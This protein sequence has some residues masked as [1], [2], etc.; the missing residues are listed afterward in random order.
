MQRELRLEAIKALS[1][2]GECQRGAPRCWQPHPKLRAPPAG[3]GGCIGGTP[4][5]G[6]V[7]K[8]FDALLSAQRA[9]PYV[10]ARQAVDCDVAWSE[11]H[12]FA[13]LRCKKCAGSRI[14]A[15]SSGR[16]AVGLDRQ[17]LHE[18]GGEAE[19]LRAAAH[20]P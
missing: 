18:E 8:S 17:L 1:A 16:V 7:N 19:G 20:E 13:Y 6:F 10:S 2:R 11:T 5:H 4:L 14:S 15:R 12:R 9:R 3:R